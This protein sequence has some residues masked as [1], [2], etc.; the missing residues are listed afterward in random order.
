M[1]TYTTDERFSAVRGETPHPHGFSTALSRDSTTGNLDPRVVQ[2]V[3]DWMLQI[4]GLQKADAGMYECQVNT[5]HPMLSAHVSLNVLSPRASIAEGS[6]L[7]VMSGSGLS[8]TCLVHD[9][10]Q[11]PLHVFWY[12]G[13]RVV[14]YDNQY[15]KVNITSLPRQQ[16][17]LPHHWD[18]SVDGGRP[19]SRLTIYNASKQHSGSYVCAPIDSAPA[20]V[21]VH[22]FHGRCVT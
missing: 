16:E 13:D 1:V 7:S 9:C 14:N 12:H 10:P 20:T 5:Q 17:A 18:D 4:R 19:V 22:V 8:I 2:P 15:S 3:E 11:S 6:E 21:H